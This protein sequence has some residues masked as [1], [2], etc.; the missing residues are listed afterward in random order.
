MWDNETGEGANVSAPTGA[1]QPKGTGKAGVVHLELGGKRMDVPMETFELTGSSVR[2]TGTGM[3]TGRRQFTAAKIG[4]QSDDLSP[5]FLGAST[6]NVAFKTM[7]IDVVEQATE[8]RPAQTFTYHLHD[9]FLSGLHESG[10]KGAGIE[11]LA[12]SF[13]RMDMDG[14][15]VRNE[16]ATGGGG[17]AGTMAVNGLQFGGGTIALNSVA[18]GVSSPSDRATGMA[19]GKRR[20]QNVV[21]TKDMDESSKSLMHALQTNQKLTSCTLDLNGSPPGHQGPASSASKFE[22]QGVNVT[23]VQQSSSGNPIETISLAFESYEMGSQNEG[24]AEA[25][26]DAPAMMA[27]EA[28][29]QGKWDAPILEWNWGTTTP[30]RQS[31]SDEE[32]GAQVTGKAQMKEFSFTIPSGPPT[33]RFLTAQA[34]NERLKSVTLAPKSGPGYALALA[35]VTDLQIANGADGGITSVKLAYQGLTEHA[36]D[37]EESTRLGDEY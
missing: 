25:P 13:G 31:G 29:K 12:F 4:R 3:P 11:E 28:E 16:P 35:R 1:A 6:R 8:D 17:G 22:L 20:I 5:L 10:G 23:A 2:D 33:V 26:A 27:V 24:G 36:G 19:T 34:N 30:T 21:I 9:A 7:D 37:K 32:R 14:P 15:N 18:W